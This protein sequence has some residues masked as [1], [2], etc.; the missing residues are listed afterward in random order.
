[1]IIST[2]LALMGYLL[3]LLH[4]RPLRMLG[5]IFVCPKT[6]SATLPKQVFIFGISIEHLTR[7]FDLAPGLA[8][9]IYSHSNG[10]IRSAPRLSERSLKGG[11]C[12]REARSATACSIL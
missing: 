9:S 5:P 10:T 2:G 12:R 8:V 11:T 1:M 3:T 6:S 4:E 7:S